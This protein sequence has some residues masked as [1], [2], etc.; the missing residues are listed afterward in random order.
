[1]RFG[2]CGGIDIAERAL[3]AGFDY[4]EVGASSFANLEPFDPEVYRSAHA[5]AS[6]LFFP[7]SIKLFGPERTSYLDYA[8]QAVERAAEIGIEVMVIGSGGARRAPEGMA[9]ADE[10]FV[11]IAGEVARIASRHGIAVA[12]ESLNRTETNVGNDLGRL[13]HLLRNEGVGYTADSYH[14]LYEWNADAVNGA[15]SGSGAP[16]AAHWA[17]QLPFTPTHVHIADLPRFAPRADDPMLTGFVNRL[18]ELEY[19]AR[20]SLECKLP[21]MEVETLRNAVDELR[22]LF[23]R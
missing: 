20:V 6:N 10:N 13:A 11:R 17:G 8:E 23:A 9:N 7:A 16:D 22:R 18:R 2:I 4:V 14:V 1:M 12:P 3:A 19:D 5:E 15:G 21:D